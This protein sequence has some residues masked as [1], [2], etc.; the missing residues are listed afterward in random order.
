M[1]QVNKWS[2]LAKCEHKYHVKLYKIVLNSHIKECSRR[3]RAS[4]CHN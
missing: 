2:V 3:D 1:K 4:F